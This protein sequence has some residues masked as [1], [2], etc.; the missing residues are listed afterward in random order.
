MKRT[1]AWLLAVVLLLTLLTG[2]KNDSGNS[3]IE[4]TIK[5]TISDYDKE[6]VVPVDEQSSSDVGMLVKEKK[7]VYGDENVM[8][9]RVE[10]QTENAYSISI[11]GRFMDADGRT[12]A[13]KNK[14]FKGFAPGFGTYF[15]FQPNKSFESFSY[16]LTAKPYEGEALS[17]YFEVGEDIKLVTEKLMRDPE[18]KNTFEK[19]CVGVGVVYPLRNNGAKALHYAADFVLFDKNGEIYM[20]D[21]Q[22]QEKSLASHEEGRNDAV[23]RPCF[24]SETLWENKDD[25]VMPEELQGELVAIMAIREISDSPLA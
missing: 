19:P 18:T 22:L 23:F 21:D 14:T 2:C 13:T 10:N 9:L 3:D 1:Y 25:F 20:I 15:V 7:C 12:V 11:S 4:V 8:I 17:Q 5:G 24:V 16:T 6:N